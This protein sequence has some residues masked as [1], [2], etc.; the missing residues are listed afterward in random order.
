M[1]STGDRKE[2]HWLLDMREAID[3]IENHPQYAKGR[4]AFEQD[5]FFQV[6]I[7]Y[8]MERIGECASH[9]RREYD[10]DSKHPEY[11]LARYCRYETASC[12]LVLECR[13]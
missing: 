1:T 4:Q 5:E 8:Y 12:A 6:W 7:F 10:Y 3:K 11:R 2:L 9:L 13:L